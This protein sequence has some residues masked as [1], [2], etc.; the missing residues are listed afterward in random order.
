MNIT[1]SAVHFEAT[2]KLHEFAVKEFSALQKYYTHDLEGNIVL[3]ENGNRKVVEMRMSAY[4]KVLPVKLEGSDF[5]KTIPQ[6]V[7]KLKKQLKAHKSKKFD[8]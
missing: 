2:D 1:F 6:A 7:D 3:K 4:G 8:R 5:Y